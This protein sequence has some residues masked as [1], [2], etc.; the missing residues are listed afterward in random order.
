MANPGYPSGDK[1]GRGS[2]RSTDQGGRGNLGKSRF[3]VRVDKNGG[4]C[5]G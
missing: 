4:N 2:F 5:G 1:G 3:G